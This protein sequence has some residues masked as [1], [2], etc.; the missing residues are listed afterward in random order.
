MELGGGGREYW[1]ADPGRRELF[2]R[3]AKKSFF[4]L[5]Y[6]S[7]SMPTNLRSDYKRIA[8]KETGAPFSSDHHANGEA[9][10]N[11]KRYVRWKS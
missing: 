2:K 4:R 7:A 9:K 6:Q 10:M 1:E 8:S 3:E 5:P 11:L